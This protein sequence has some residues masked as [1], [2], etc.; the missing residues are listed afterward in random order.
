M[1]SDEE[2]ALLIDENQCNENNV[3]PSPLADITAKPGVDDSARK[4][5]A[6]LNT[7]QVHEHTNGHNTQLNLESQQEMNNTLSGTRRRRALSLD[8]D[9]LRDTRR[10]TRNITNLNNN[11]NHDKKKD[12]TTSHKKRHKKHHSRTNGDKNHHQNRCKSPVQS[13]ASRSL[14]SSKTQSIRFPQNINEKKHV[15]NVSIVSLDSKYILHR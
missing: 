8:Y 12:R 7:P 9:I 11:E 14:F 5:N 15:L 1:S 3:G 13:S 4:T 2:S 6:D 10:Q